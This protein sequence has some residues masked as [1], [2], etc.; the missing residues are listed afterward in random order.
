MTDPRIA[1]LAENLITYSCKLKKG[2][3][4]IVEGGIEAKPL[5]I[6][7]VKKAREIGAHPF[8]RLTDECITREILMGVDVPYAKLACKYALPL[9]KEAEAYI[10]IAATKNIFESADVPEEN[11]NI[12]KKHYSKPIHIDCR[13]EKHNWVILR[14]PNESMAQLAQTSVEC[15]ENLYFNVCNLDYAKMDKAMQPLKKLMESTDKVRIVAPDTDL[16]F[17][18]KGQK[19]V[20]C[21]GSC[22][23]PDG[24]I[25]TSPIL[26]SV[27]GIIRF[28]IPTLADGKMHN[29]VTL[30]FKDGAVVQAKSSNTRHL[31]QKLD[32]DEGARYIGEFALGVNPYITE[33]MFDTLFDE[34]MGGSLHLALGNSY[35]ECCNG[36]KSAEHWDIVQSH[37][38]DHGGGEIYFDDVLIRKDGLF[39]LPE[40]EDLNPENLK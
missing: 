13:C 27:S 5:I 15:F 26:T 39:V 36:N 16:T 20:V 8:V 11:K 23:I 14:W 28:N 34:K 25:M 17:S 24:E 31:N 2:Q 35:P 37:L 1:K 32:S 19:A 18:I 33:G 22:N 30:T 21:A 38:P 10:G 7:L 4:L 6:A 40:L 3:K 29:D 12:F 9:F